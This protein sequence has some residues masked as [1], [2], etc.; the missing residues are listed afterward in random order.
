MTSVKK[1]GLIGNPIG[2]SGSPAL[3]GA[4]YGGRYGYDLIETDTFEEAWDRFVSGYAAINVTAPFKE[5]AFEQAV[6]LTH[7]GKGTLSGPCRKI[8][9]TNLMVKTPSGMDAH[10]SD[11]SGV[12]VSVAECYFPGV[13]RQCKERYGSTWAMRVHQFM[14]SSLGDL[15]PSSPHALVVGCGGA[16][17]AA[18]VAAAEMGF[19]VVLMNRNEQK[20]RSFALQVAEYGFMVDPLSDL[21]GAIK[22]CELVIYTLPVQVDALK[23]MEAEDFRSDCG[24]PKVIL[25]ANYKTPAFSG[26]I[27][28]AAMQGGA[29]Y[30]GGREWLL[31]QAVAGYALMTGEEPDA[32][33][34]R[35]NNKQTTYNGT[36]QS[37]ANR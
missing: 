11:F 26:S 22:D 12:M 32:D 21:R 10:N 13:A 1:Y 37:D 19:G 36:Q 31:W 23:E 35:K 8:G 5:Q 15:F 4:A 20:A 6:G 34:M 29:R 14:R 33:A 18:A 24:V 3:F 9:A 30:I 16:G 2:G 17:K 28:E 27:L 7:D 25:E